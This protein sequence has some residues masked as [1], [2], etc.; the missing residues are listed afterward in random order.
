MALYRNIAGL[1]DLPYAPTMDRVQA[2][3][4]MRYAETDPYDPFSAIERQSNI[5]NYND[6]IQPVTIPAEQVSAG[7][8]Y[9]E[10]TPQILLPSPYESNQPPQTTVQPI[11]AIAVSP[12]GATHPIDLD[13]FSLQTRYGN[14]TTLDRVQNILDSPLL[15]GHAND[16]VTPTTAVLPQTTTTATTTSPGI[17]GYALPLAVLA[18]IFV[19]AIKGETFMPNRRKL[20]VVGGAGL[21]YYLMNK[22]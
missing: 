13:P 6:T 10:S 11:D 9:Y 16:L 18:G 22:K 21:L 5:A 17:K 20:A 14:I 2:V 19:V 8:Y 7:D 15:P 1:R 4:D 3:L 12:T